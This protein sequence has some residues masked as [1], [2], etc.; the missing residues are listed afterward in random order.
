MHSGTKTNGFYDYN[1]VGGGRSNRALDK[2]PLLRTDARMLRRWVEH[3]QEPRHAP[4]NPDH[5]GHVEDRLP[6]ERGNEESTHQHSYRG[7]ERRG[8]KQRCKF[9]ARR[10]TQL[11]A[12]SSRP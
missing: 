2:V 5:A 3:Q 1:L 6:A 9:T 4:D 8:C 7:A 11:Y 12:S 10:L